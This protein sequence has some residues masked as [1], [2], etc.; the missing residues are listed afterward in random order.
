[1]IEAIGRAFRLARHK[2][3]GGLTAWYRQFGA[4][5][6]V[7]GPH[8]IGTVR[9]WGRDRFLCAKSSTTDFPYATVKQLATRW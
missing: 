5:F 3:T 4:P 8:L 9:E 2:T 1:M 6:L 7:F